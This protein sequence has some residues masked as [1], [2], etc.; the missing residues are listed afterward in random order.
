MY[1][2]PLLFLIFM[3]TFMVAH[4]SVVVPNLFV[5]NFSVDDYKASCQNW[6]LSV[7]SDGV[8]YVANN[9]VLLTF[10]GNTWKLYETPDKSVING[11]TFLNDTIYTISEGS[12]NFTSAGIVESLW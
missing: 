9:S 3:V 5:K 10:D 4:A 1:R 8:L 6:G 11:V 12:L 7:A 2:L